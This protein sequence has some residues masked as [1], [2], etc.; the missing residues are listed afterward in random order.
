MSAEYLI[1][2]YGYVALL[3][4]ALLAHERGREKS[5]SAQAWRGLSL[6]AFVLAALAREIS[7][8]ARAAPTSCSAT[9]RRP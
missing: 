1:Q 2:T 5:S 8:R 4:G 9:S 3:L 7:C 6:L